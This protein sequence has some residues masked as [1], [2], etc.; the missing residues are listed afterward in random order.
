MSANGKSGLIRIM[1]VDDHPMMR[2]ALRMIVQLEADFMIAAE[3]ESG[4]MAIDSLAEAKPDVVLMD[5]SMPEMNG[6]ETTRRLRE[7]QPDLKIVGLTLYEQTTYLEEMIEAGASGYV[8][9]TGSP[10]EI[11]KA[12][13][14]VAAGGTYF[15]QSI[16]R[17]T[18]TSARRRMP[19]RELSGE[20]LAV[21]KLLANGRTKNE[22]AESLGVSIS[23]VDARRAA[24]MGKLGLRSRAEL[25]R[26]A[27]ER[28]WLEG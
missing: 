26:M 27:K 22:I 15:D 3:A 19:R 12:V 7:L 11:V 21:A 24:V 17:Q 16:P 8:L 20:E 28:G 4:Q 9:K 14:T 13:R 2:E 25:V 10:V 18:S 5:G 6:M 23:E 1:I